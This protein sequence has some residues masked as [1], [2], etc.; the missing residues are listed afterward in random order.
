MADDEQSASVEDSRR[1]KHIGAGNAT[2][3]YHECFQKTVA[4]MD[5]FLKMSHGEWLKEQAGEVGNQ[6]SPA[7]EERMK[8]L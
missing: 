8:E 4:E 1:R 5:R 7:A 2:E 6:A 3:T